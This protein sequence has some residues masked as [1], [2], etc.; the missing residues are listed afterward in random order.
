MNI[1]SVLLKG[2]LGVV[3]G[4]VV[5]WILLMISASLFP[6][7][8]EAVMPLFLAP[9]ILI[10]IA[11][12][13]WGAV[14]GKPSPTYTD[15][16]IV[17]KA[18]V[19]RQILGW[20]LIVVMWILAGLIAMSLSGVASYGYT[21]IYSTT[22]PTPSS[23]P[24]LLYPGE[25]PDEWQVPMAPQEKNTDNE[26]AASAVAIAITL[27]ILIVVYTR[28]KDRW[29]Y[30]NGRLTIDPAYYLKTTAIIGSGFL[31][32]IGILTLACKIFNIGPP[33]ELAKIDYGTLVLVLASAL[34]YFLISRTS[35]KTLKMF[36]VLTGIL[37]ALSVLFE[38]LVLHE[39]D[40]FAL[41]ADLVFYIL[42]YYH[43]FKYIKSATEKLQ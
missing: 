12:A 38:V 10:V 19:G 14:N 9:W 3:V 34:F 11:F 32:V 5:S 43:V 33:A 30:Q 18:S 7:M 41:I 23:T 20:V 31:F 26:E 35:G 27:T 4:G 39:F 6:K 21:T 22:Q 24:V 16:E 8:P 29:I 28:I 13:A 36:F 17:Y 40:V 2:L 42:I 15:G 1:K 25:T 37:A